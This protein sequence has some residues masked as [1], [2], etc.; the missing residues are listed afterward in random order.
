MSRSNN[1]SSDTESLP[2][3]K[4]PEKKSFLHSEKQEE[5]YFLAEAFVACVSYRASFVTIVLQGS[6]KRMCYGQNL[7]AGCVGVR[8]SRDGTHHPF[9]SSRKRGFL[10]C[11]AQRRRQLWLIPILENF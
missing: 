5:G 7:K 8:R 1:A 3:W 6:I 4:L 11:Q 9:E 2:R 10:H